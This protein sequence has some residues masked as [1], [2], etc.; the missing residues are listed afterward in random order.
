MIKKFKFSNFQLLD[1]PFTYQGLKFYYVE[2]FYVAMK[3][4]N[5][6]LQHEI[7]KMKPGESKK[8]G[9]NIELRSDWEDI[10]IRVMEFALEKKFAPGTS[11]YKKL[12]QTK[13]EYLVETNYWHDN[14]WG[15]CMCQKCQDIPGQNLLGKLLMEIR[16]RIN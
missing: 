13:D 3:T 15:N 11:W 1:E 10:K 5:F 7:S 9:R 6:E 16:K 14:I 8:F 2:T 12:K 4:L